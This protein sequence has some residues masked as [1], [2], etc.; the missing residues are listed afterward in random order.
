LQ[1]NLKVD[2]IKELRT[3]HPVIRNY[4]W[5]KFSTYKNNVLLVIGS[6]L[7]G[8]VTITHYTDEDRACD[9]VNW[10]LDQDPSKPVRISDFT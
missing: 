10:V 5:I 9:F 3:F 2:I 6:T 1:N 7:T 8:Q 4:W